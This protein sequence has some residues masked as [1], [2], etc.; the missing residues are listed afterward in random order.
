[1]FFDNFFVDNN[2]EEGEHIHR[3][4]IT[5]FFSS[6]NLV[7][8]EIFLYKNYNSIHLC[9]DKFF[10]QTGKFFSLIQLIRVR[11]KKIRFCFFIKY[12]TLLIYLFIS[13]HHIS[14]LKL[15][16]LDLSQN[17]STTT[18]QKDGEIRKFNCLRCTHRTHIRSYIQAKKR[19]F[20]PSG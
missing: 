7:A 9:N 17:R 3:I 15:F 2:S 12:R 14:I 13:I 1:M 16:S 6:I 19:Y 11:K 20:P 5:I 10:L 4:K 18:L 8:L